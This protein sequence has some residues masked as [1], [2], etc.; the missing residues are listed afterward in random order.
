MKRFYI[1]AAICSI[2]LLASTLCFG[3]Q[4]AQYQ[5]KIATD[6]ITFEWTLDANLIHI[7]LSAKTSGWVGIGFNP[8][9]A[10][11][12]ANF[13]I[14]YVKDNKVKITNQ[15]GNSNFSHAPYTAAGKETGLTDISGKEA[16]GLTDI[17]FTMPLKSKNNPKSAIKPDAETIVMLAHGPDYV[18]SFFAK[19][20][21]K[22]ELQV[23]LSTGEYKQ[24]Q[25]K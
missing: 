16:N 25:F 2:I 8:T 13:V 1:P 15:F 14:G 21:Y 17:A 20:Q 23:N 5:H 4:A 9:H 6:Q 24:I 10:M 19:H 12:N 7:R 22:T 11:K 3:Q 18:K